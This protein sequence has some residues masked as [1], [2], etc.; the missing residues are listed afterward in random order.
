MQ[1]FNWLILLLSIYY[2]NDIL[3]MRNL[4]HFLNSSQHIIFTGFGH[5]LLCANVLLC[6]DYYVQRLLY[7]ILF[8][9]ILIVSSLY[10][11]P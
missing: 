8:I 6:N 5:S 1:V 7:N 4:F 10:N 11:I 9:K 3:F 2:S